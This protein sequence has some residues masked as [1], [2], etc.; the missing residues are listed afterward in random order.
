MLLFLVHVHDEEQQPIHTQ[1]RMGW[2]FP[3]RMG[4]IAIPTARC[5]SSIYAEC[6]QKKY[7]SWQVICHGQSETRVP[8]EPYSNSYIDGM[9]RGYAPHYVLMLAL[10]RV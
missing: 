8:D 10:C 1:H 6:M 4:S 3:M 9:P 7:T 2:L 5:Q